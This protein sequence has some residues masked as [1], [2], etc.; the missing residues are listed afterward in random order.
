MTPHVE[1]THVPARSLGYFDWL[2][3]GL[4]L[5]AQQGQLELTVRESFWEKPLRFRL[6]EKSPWPRI[7]PGLW[8]RLCPID[9]FCLTGRLRV[10]DRMMNFAVDV[11]DSPFTFALAL[12]ETVDVY[13]KCQCPTAFERQ[14]FALNSQVRIPYH[15]DVFAFAENIRPGMIGRPLARTTSFK[16]NCRALKAWENR[17]TPRKDNAIFAFFG[18]S[19]TPEPRR[20]DMALPAPHNYEGESTLLA[21]WGDQ[22]HHPN[23]KRARV[24]QVLRELGRPDIDARVCHTDDPAIRGPWLKTADYQ[25]ALQSAAVNVNISGLRRSIPFRF[26]DTLLCGGMVATDSLA[27][28]WHAPFEPGVEVT[29]IG[30]MGYE[31]ESRVDWSHVRERLIDLSENHGQRGNEGANRVRDAYR[32][33]WSPIAYAA[34]VLDECKNA[35]E[36]RF[37]K[38]DAKLAERRQSEAIPSHLR[39][40]G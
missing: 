11:A 31:P 14:G 29:E 22:I 20:P 28:R 19:R 26:I 3:T 7:M 36:S 5:L 34:Y 25:A 21:R 1:I 4:G 9:D 27:V 12:L 24:V 15:P 13:F 38:D 40:A 33:K 2:L 8:N 30:E 6:F 39:K 23:C 32:R 16:A 10:R 37:W 18:S 17:F 35:M